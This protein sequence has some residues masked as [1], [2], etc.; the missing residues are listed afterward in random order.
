MYKLEEVTRIH[1]EITSKC[2]ASCPQCARNVF[3]AVRDP[4]FDLADISLADFERVFEP[5]FLR[6]LTSLFM[7]GTYG[8]PVVA[9]DCLEIWKYIKKHQRPNAATGIHTNGGA[10]DKAWWSELAAHCQAAWFGIDG[11]EDT[12]HLYRQNVKWSKLMENAQAYIDAGG[13]AIWVM[14]VYKHNE[15]QVEK[16]KAVARLMGFKDFITRKTARFYLPHVGLVS[17]FPVFNTKSEITHFLEMPTNPE[18]LNTQF[19]AE[20]RAQAETNDSL[21]YET[22]GNFIENV[23]QYKLEMRNKW[24]A[25]ELNEVA[26]VS[27]DVARRFNDIPIACKAKAAKEIYVSATGL[28]WPCCFLSVHEWGQG[29]RQAQVDQLF[30][31]IEDHMDSLNFRK[32]SL[33][34]II[35]GEFFQR[36][37]PASWEQAKIGEGRI[38]E[39]AYWCPKENGYYDSQFENKNKPQRKSDANV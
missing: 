6:Q 34:E 15:H 28:V 23:R 36:H 13:N 8:E 7:C 22:G 10:K 16:A 33:R 21:A 9:P 18:F 4:S 12:N 38:Y 14:N 31:E 1:L 29:Y 17:K 39:C 20:E 11:L 37:I 25:G 30:A 2:N 3:G 5:A 19:T 35:E 32:H 24:R 27:D 26:P